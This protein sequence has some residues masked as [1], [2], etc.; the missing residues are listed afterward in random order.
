[1]DLETAKKALEYVVRRSGPRRNV[2]V[3]L[4]GGETNHMIWDTVKEI[5]AYARENEENGIRILDLQ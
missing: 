1:M 3:D 2:E 4:F 5:I